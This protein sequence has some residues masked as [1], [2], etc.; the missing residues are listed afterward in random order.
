MLP[1]NEYIIL[2]KEAEKVNEAWYTTFDAE[3]IDQAEHF[4]LTYNPY[5]LRTVVRLMDAHYQSLGSVEYESAE[6]AM[7]FLEEYFDLDDEDA[8]FVNSYEW[9]DDTKD[10]EISEALNSIEDEIKRLATEYNI[11][12]RDIDDDAV[13]PNNDFGIAVYFDN[14]NNKNDLISFIR[15]AE[16]EI[17]RTYGAMTKSIEGNVWLIRL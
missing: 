10:V 12:I 13:L 3:T 9:A 1:L 16:K 5:T 6:L 14:K 2:E 11:N 17:E 15:T 8:G 7:A 4:T